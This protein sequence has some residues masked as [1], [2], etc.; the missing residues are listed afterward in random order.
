MVICRGG[1]VVGGWG[2][3][4]RPDQARSHPLPIDSMLH[5]R[6][7]TNWASIAWGALVLSLFLAWLPVRRVTPPLVE[8]DYCYLL[9]AADRFLDGLSLTSLQPLAPHQPWEFRYEWG[10]L[11]Q[12]PAGFPLLIAAIR[13][14]L[15]CT[16]IEAC[17]FVSVVGCAVGFIGWFAF[18][19]RLVPSGVTGQ[20]LAGVA[21][22]SAFA[23]GFLINPSTDLILIAAL[24]FVMLMIL[25]ACSDLPNH[26][27]AVGLLLA[28]GTLSG[29]MVWIRYAAIF[30][31]VAAGVFL[32]FEW[33]RKRIST[34]ALLTF[35]CS[36]ALWIVGLFVVNSLFSPG[37][38][39]TQRFNLGERTGFDF[40]FSMVAQAW[41]TLTDLGYYSHHP[42][43]H[44]IIALAP[45]AYMPAL[46]SARFRTMLISLV[47]MPPQRIA[48][49]TVA[50]LLVMIIAV[51][52]LFRGKFDYIGLERY[53]FPVRPLYVVCVLAPLMLVPRRAVRVAMCGG[54]TL[55]AFWTLSQDWS[56]PLSRWAHANRTTTPSGAW[57]RIFEPGSEELYHW[58]GKHGR[59]PSIL[60]VSNFHEFV[61]LETG[62]VTVPVPQSK[63]EFEQLLGKAAQLRGLELVQPIVVLHPRNL[64][65]SHWHADIDDLKQVL[66]LDPLADAPIDLQTYLFTRSFTQPTC[67]D[68]LISTSWN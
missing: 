45:L 51:T 3:I 26:R 43:A 22:F 31:P 55:L 44:W 17:R 16:S 23:A 13:W 21:A 15:G 25:D 61:A 38:S 6:H 57:S 1:I 40:S 36:A 56:S 68:S 5:S 50:T 29:M 59:D 46:F 8:S 18:L 41:W 4:A 30:L 49:C 39:A 33:L 27:S 11:T 42:M 12:W 63:V 47:A 24:P 52:V 54:L 19:R 48:A 66:E 64:W 10:F 34:D 65:R 7:R 60:I 9:L 58:L 20:F 37:G 14:M 53:Y 32:L 28:A 62:I 35:A 2:D 67:D